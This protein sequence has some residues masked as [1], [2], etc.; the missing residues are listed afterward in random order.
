MLGPPAGLA[1]W[2]SLPVDPSTFKWG[3][4]ASYDGHHSEGGPAW[5]GNFPERV[6]ALTVELLS[7]G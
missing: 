1:D 3:F 4:K 7:S 5:S 6:V 2:L